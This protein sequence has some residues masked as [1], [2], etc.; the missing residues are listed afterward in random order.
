MSAGEERRRPRRGRPA[1]LTR[2]AICSA[3]I[4]LIDRDGP[5]ALTM[6]AL[7]QELGVEAM[8]LYRHVGSKDELLD[9]VAEQLFAQIEPR[10]ISSDWAAAVRGYASSVRGLARAHPQAFA[11]VAARSGG[12]RALQ[13][14]ED[15]LASLRASGFT[16]ARAVAAYRLV[17]AYTSGYVLAEIGGPALAEDAIP[18]RMAAL[19]SLARQLTGEP[20]QGSF[21]AGLET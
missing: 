18:P 19:R 15:L 2:G 6:R 3:A 10:G 4:G 16:P 17:A 20:P 21:R 7:A 8:S 14:A 1:K 11:L 13:P 5:A 12:A 9:A